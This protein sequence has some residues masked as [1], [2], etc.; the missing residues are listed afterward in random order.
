MPEHGI[1]LVELLDALEQPLGRGELGRLAEPRLA[2]L[3]PLPLGAHQLDLNHQVLA[4]GKE[5]VERRVERADRHRIAVH[6]LEQA[7]EVGALERQQLGERA[8]IGGERPG[9]LLLERGQLAPDRAGTGRIG[10]FQLGALALELVLAALGLGGGEDHRHH[11][12]Q[13]ALLEEHVLGAAEPDP[14]GAERPG[15]GGIARDV[16]VR[17]H[18]EAADGVG[19]FHEDGEL[20][21]H[22]RG[23]RRRLAEHHL[24]GRAVERDP[25]TLL[26]RGVAGSEAMGPLVELKL[27]G[28]AHARLPHAA[29]HDGGVA[30]EPTRGGEDPLRRVHAVNVVG[31]G[32]L[33][34]Q[35]DLLLA[36]AR[37]GRVG[38]EHHAPDRRSRRGREPG[39]D[40]P[41]LGA[42]IE[43]R[44]EELIEG[45][46]LHAHHRLL[47]GDEALV[48][49]V[50]RYADGRLGGAL[51]GAGLEQV[52]RALLDRELEVLDVAVVPLEPGGDVAKLAVRVGHLGGQLVDR[53]RR[54]HAR[55]HV[56][57]LRVGQ[58][59]A[60]EDPLAG[61]RVARESHARPRGRPQ[62]S[63][64]HG[65]DV[66]GSAEIVGDLVLPPVVLGALVVPRLEH[67][68]AGQRE[69][70]ERV[71]RE[72]LAGPPTH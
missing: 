36:P 66:D 52:E 59:L 55:H 16:R 49:H 9:H 12:G 7:L 64:H 44:V 62:V 2:L 26:H 6:R 61:G 4:L 22:L 39:G 17:A 45:R 3:T 60:V 58:E 20:A 27:R 25:V 46:G 29:R 48:H 21:P 15:L 5:L 57:A 8:A 13:A 54:A 50:H 43:P 72:L 41:E 68:V 42:G 33:A 51:A 53:P 65:L 10:G 31:G 67:R 18:L 34:H 69:L 56:L 30:R 19:P 35:D 37:G 70:L 40:Y 32:L 11:V 24:S 38:V 14:L 1:E 63:E 23:Q 71:L 47:A 28:A